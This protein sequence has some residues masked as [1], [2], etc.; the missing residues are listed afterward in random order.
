M[1][2]ETTWDIA[3]A[4]GTTTVHAGDQVQLPDDPA[5]VVWEVI[6]SEREPDESE[7]G[8]GWCPSLRCRQ[9]GGD[10]T[11]YAADRNEDGTIDLCGDAVAAA[12][13]ANGR[14]H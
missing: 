12:I 5:D 4:D 3:H 13:S 9:I 10:M 11:L 2:T 1:T 7:Y 6:G 14:T 8:D